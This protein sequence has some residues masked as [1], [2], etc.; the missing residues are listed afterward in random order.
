MGRRRRLLRNK[1]RYPLLRWRSETSLRCCDLESGSPSKLRIYKTAV[2]QNARALALW[3]SPAGL[4]P[5][6]YT[7]AWSRLGW[8]G[9]GAP[10]LLGRRWS[11]HRFCLRLGRR[12]SGCRWRR[13][14]APFHQRWR[15]SRRLASAILSFPAIEFQSRRG[16]DRLRR[17][18]RLWRR[19]LRRR[20]AWRWLARRG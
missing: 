2:F 11:G 9:D 4:K 14:A 16:P 6:P 10:F 8:A 15:R 5:G 7:I 13:R 19:E 3:R 20:R 12:R 17:T 1:L 18:R